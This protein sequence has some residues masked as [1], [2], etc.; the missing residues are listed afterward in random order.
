MRGEDLVDLLVLD[1]L[2]VEQP[3][4][5]LVEQVAVVDEQL[6]GAAVGLL[7]DR[8]DLLVAGLAQRLGDREVVAREPGASGSSV[9]IAYSW[10]IERAIAVTRLRSSAAPVVIR[11]K[12]ICSETRPASSTFM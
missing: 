5:D 4:G 9:P 12:V 3:L 6:L 10:T 1:D 11:P 2:V 7:G 8:L